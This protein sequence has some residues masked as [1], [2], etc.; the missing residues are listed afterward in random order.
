MGNPILYNRMGET[1][2]IIG[3]IFWDV[4]PKTNVIEVKLWGLSV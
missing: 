3:V 4:L 2:Y 1:D